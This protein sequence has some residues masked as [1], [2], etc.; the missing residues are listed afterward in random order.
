[1]DRLL[2][3]K[4]LLLQQEPAELGQRATEE[5]KKKVR[6]NEHVPALGLFMGFVDEIKRN[7]KHQ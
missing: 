1:M 2:V 7:K 3:F 5:L 4:D 6:I